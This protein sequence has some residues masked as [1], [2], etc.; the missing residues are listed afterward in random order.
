MNLTATEPLHLRS[1]DPPSDSPGPARRYPLLE[2]LLEEKGLK[3]KGIYTVRDAAS[4]FGVSVRTIQEWVRDGKLIARDLPGR[5]RFL[6]EDLER[7]L[8]ESVRRREDPVE[9]R[10]PV[11]GRAPTRRR[12]HTGKP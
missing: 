12:I 1:G 6:S 11:P 10:A 9:L 8:R 5:G 3:L 7:F 2:A 4:I